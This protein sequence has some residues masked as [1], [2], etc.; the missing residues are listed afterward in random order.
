MR[1]TITLDPDVDALLRKRM[2][3]RGIGFK[4]AVNTVL[5]EALNPGGAGAGKYTKTTAMGAPR[6]PL[7]NALRMAGEL[8]DEEILHKLRIGK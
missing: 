3:E 6:V 1:T 8:E 2:A 4:E 7:E 5:R